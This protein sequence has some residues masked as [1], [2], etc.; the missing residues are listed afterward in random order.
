MF[1]LEKRPFIRCVFTFVGGCIGVGIFSVPIV[2][3]QNGIV[4]SSILF[5]VL[6]GAVLFIHLL[7]IDVAEATPDRRYSALSASPEL[8]TDKRKRQK[9]RLTGRIAPYLGKQTSYLIAITVIGSSVAVMV[10]YAFF[11]GGAYSVIHYITDIA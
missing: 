8:A 9:H 1:S 5:F 7:Y 4:L 3:A 2:F 6:V 11:V 10:V